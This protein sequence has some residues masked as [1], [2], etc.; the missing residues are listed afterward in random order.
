MIQVRRSLVVSA[1][2]LTALTGLSS[3][4]ALARLAVPAHAE[5]P[6]GEDPPGEDVSEVLEAIRA[7]TAVPGMVAL[8]LQDGEV[9]AWGAAGVRAQGKSERVTIDDPFHLGSC[10]KAMTSTLVAI[11]VEEG[12]LTWDTKI[13][14]VLPELK[15]TSDPGYAEATI[16]HLVR[17]RAGIAERQRP[18]VAAIYEQFAG[19]EGTPAEQRIAVARLALKAPPHTKPGEAMDYSNYGYMSAAAMIERLSG[20]PWEEL[21]LEKVARPLGME[22][23]VVGSPAGAGVPVGHQPADDSWSPLPPGPAGIL[24]E[25]MGPAGLFSCNLEDWSKFVAAHVAGARGQDGLVAAATFERLQTDPGTNA[26][27][28]GW[29]LGERQWSWGKGKTLSHNGSDGTWFSQVMAMPEWDLIVL[30]AVNCAGTPG[31]RAAT[32]AQEA[33]LKLAG[34][35][36]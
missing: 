1:L 6:S 24:A 30:A 4:P 13:L 18:E 22:S 26:Y 33:L 27:A 3:A 14:D 29:A 34:F 11:C 23:A 19:L 32:E 10:T 20:R 31:T 15:E 28:C 17:H 7:E 36:D 25:C 12:L 16:D 9:L 21:I 35:A 8:I 2:A 5:V